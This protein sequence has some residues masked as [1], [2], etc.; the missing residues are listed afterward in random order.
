[1]KP[2]LPRKITRTARINLNKYWS[3][4]ESMMVT[5][6]NAQSSNANAAGNEF[7]DTAMNNEINDNISNEQREI[8]NTFMRR[9]NDRNSTASQRCTCHFCLISDL[10][11][12][13][14]SERNEEVTEL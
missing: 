7:V 13:T 11:N 1:M 3:V 2:R 5:D 12:V 14:V 9:N 10:R 4:F 8:D 6:R